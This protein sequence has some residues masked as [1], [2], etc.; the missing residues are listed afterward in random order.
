VNPIDFITIEIIRVKYRS[1]CGIS[2]S[3]L[4]WI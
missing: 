1:G 2:D 3:C 4:R